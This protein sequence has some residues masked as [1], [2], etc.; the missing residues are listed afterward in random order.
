LS[1]VEARRSSSS[2]LSNLGSQVIGRRPWSV[3]GEEK[4]DF[5]LHGL[6]LRPLPSPPAVS[7]DLLAILDV[8][9]D[10]HW[11]TGNFLDVSGAK[12][13]LVHEEQRLGPGARPLNLL[14]S[15]RPSPT[16]SP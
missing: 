3:A 8:D 4:C 5:P 13:R 12:S 10:L 16:A 2:L 11:P 6:P 1:V 14:A 9:D 7:Q 15:F